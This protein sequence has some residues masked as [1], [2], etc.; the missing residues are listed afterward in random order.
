MRTVDIDL[1]NSFV[2][3]RSLGETEIHQQSVESLAEGWQC[4][5]SDVG[6]VRLASVAKAEVTQALIDEVAA[7]WQVTVELAKVESGVGGV[8]PAYQDCSRLGV[9][10]WLAMLA[11]RQLVSGGVCVVSAGSALTADWVAAN[12]EHLGGFIAPGRGR[13]LRSLYCDVANVLNMPVD[14]AP[15]TSLGRSTEECVAGGIGVL[16]AGFI[17]DVAE[18]QL[19]APIFIYGGDSHAM[20]RLCAQEHKSRVR[21]LNNPVLDGLV[22]ALP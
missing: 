22:I 3:W 5:W 4:L 10:R 19:E 13:M 16:M 2:K 9:D 1:G 7:R 17:N 20:L 8:Q 12:G 18:R 21:L 14:L 11:C 15:Q 6:R